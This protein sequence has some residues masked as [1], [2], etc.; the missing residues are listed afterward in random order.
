MRA[1]GAGAAIRLT[2]SKNSQTPYS[3]SPD[4]KW[5]AFDETSDQTNTDLWILPLE[6]LESDH[7]KPGKPEPLLVTPADEYGPMISPD[8]R[9]LAYTST[10]SGH[11]EVYVRR[12]PGFEGKWQIS[13][14]GGQFPVWS[15]K[16]PELFYRS[17]EGMMV[18]GYT[19]SGGAFVAGKPRFWGE[20]KDLSVWFDLAP[21]G[22][23]FA[24]VH[25]A[26]TEQKGPTHV[27]FLLNFFDEL[28]RRSPASK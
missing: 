25:E 12:F 3:F 28:R 20:K 26:A 1:D 2:E 16:T 14:G 4:G 13:T 19:V 6:G 15:K 10:E 22:K 11:Y 27:T 21:D 5:L 7:L 23:R 17:D 9:W 24:V 8:G 18:A